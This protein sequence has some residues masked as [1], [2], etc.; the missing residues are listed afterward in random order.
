M[1]W[2]QTKKFE[3]GTS[4]IPL[5]SDVSG[6]INGKTVTINIS[7]DGKIIAYVKT[8]GI[9]ESESI[10]NSLKKVIPEGEQIYGTN[11]K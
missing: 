6:K 11:I 2:K 1:K 7:G 4:E 9:F 3:D 8:V 10:I 5:F